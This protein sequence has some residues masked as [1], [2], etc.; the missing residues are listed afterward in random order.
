[1]S[2]ILVNNPFNS[3]KFELM[4]AFQSLEDIHPIT[5]QQILSLSRYSDKFK[6]TLKLR[7]KESLYVKLNKED[8]TI[9]EGSSPSRKNASIDKETI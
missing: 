8:I 6:L 4:A 9:I 1:M 3:F 2:P 7:N 5:L